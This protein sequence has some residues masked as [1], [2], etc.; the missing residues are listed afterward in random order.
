MGCNEQQWKRV[1]KKQMILALHACNPDF[2][3]KG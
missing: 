1:F 2:E 3:T